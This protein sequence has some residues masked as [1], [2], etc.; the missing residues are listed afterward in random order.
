MTEAPSARPVAVPFAGTATPLDD[1]T[2]LLPE[3]FAPASALARPRWSGKR[4][5]VQFRDDRREIREP[6]LGAWGLVEHVNLRLFV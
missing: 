6:C 3:R 4:C 2:S 1:R 5:H